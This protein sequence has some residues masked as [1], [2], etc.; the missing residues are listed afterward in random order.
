MTT[1]KT[2]TFISPDDWHLH[3]RDRDSGI[4]GAVGLAT[5]NIFP[6]A[7]I[8]PNLTPPITGVSQANAYRERILAVTHSKFN[9]MMTLY[10]TDTTQ[11]SDIIEMKQLDYMLAV[12]YYPAGATTNSDAG[13]THLKNVYPQL[14]KMEE[15]QVF[16]PQA[17][18]ALYQ[19]RP[20]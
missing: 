20:N 15:L 2:I 16:R 11:I 3:L 6:R 9:P 5:A 19:A 4:L 18:V 12:K 1:Y 14:E 17:D 10:L 13:I 7:L 8:M